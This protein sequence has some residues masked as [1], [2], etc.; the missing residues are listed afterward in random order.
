[1]SHGDGI[2]D[3]IIRFFP[4]DFISYQST[5]PRLS[6]FISECFDGDGGDNDDDDDDD[7]SHKQRVGNTPLILSLQNTSQP[8]AHPRATKTIGAVTTNIV[9]TLVCVN[10]RQ[11]ISS[12][13]GV[14]SGANKSVSETLDIGYL[15]MLF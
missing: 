10:K 14:L 8:N 3:I 5:I 9:L 4:N 12:I 13:H 7:V 2:W 1:M 6:S 15:V 11:W